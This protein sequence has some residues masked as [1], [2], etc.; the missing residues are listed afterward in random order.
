MLLP[1]D[2]CLYALQATIP[3]LTRSSLHRCFKVERMNRTLKEATVRRYHYGTR[4][5]LQ[6]HLK[7]FLDAYTFAKRPKT[8]KGRTVFAFITEKWTSEPKRSRLHPNHLVPGP[9]S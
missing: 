9:N 5:E 1:L 6:A 7:T 4:D 8:L 3:Q 2:D